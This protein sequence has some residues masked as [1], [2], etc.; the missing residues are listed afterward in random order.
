MRNSVFDDGD[1]LFMHA[2]R[3][4]LVVIAVDRSRSRDRSSL[5]SSRMTTLTIAAF[6]RCTVLRRGY[7]ERR[8]CELRD[9]RS[10]FS[11]IETLADLKSPCRRWRSSG[12]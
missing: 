5:R 3:N 12:G 9:V 8:K 7:F 2:R 1:V 4:R 10:T 11:V 6:I